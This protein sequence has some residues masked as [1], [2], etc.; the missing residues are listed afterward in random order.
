MPLP[1]TDYFAVTAT[2]GPPEIILGADKARATAINRAKANPGV[3][4]AI[5]ELLRVGAARMP[6]EP[7]VQG[8]IFPVA[9]PALGGTD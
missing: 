8:S 1:N 6:T 4:Y 9:A 5:Y 3:E 7:E 2:N